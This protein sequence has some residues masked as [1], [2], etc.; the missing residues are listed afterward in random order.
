MGRGGAALRRART[1]PDEHRRA[2][3]KLRIFVWNCARSAAQ[4]RPDTAPRIR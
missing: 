4:S 1:S 2:V 3:L